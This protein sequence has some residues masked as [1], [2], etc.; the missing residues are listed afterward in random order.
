VR[1][2][3]LRRDPRAIYRRHVVRSRRT[4]LGAVATA[5]SVLAG[6]LAAVP[7]DAQQAQTGTAQTP[8][9]A[10]LSSDP[11]QPVVAT[12]VIV[13]R[14]PVRLSPGTRLSRVR[15]SILDVTGPN[16]AGSVPD[17]AFSVA[18]APPRG[19]G[20]A[21]NLTI[22]TDLARTPGNYTVLL[23]SRSVGR[24]RQT[25]ELSVTVQLA[26]AQVSVPTRL[27]IDQTRG[28]VG[29]RSETRNDSTR[30]VVEETS[31]RRAIPALRVV[32]VERPN[33]TTGENTGV[34]DFPREVPILPGQLR[35]LRY[36]VRGR[37]PLG[38]TTGTLALSAPQLGD[39]ITVPYEVTVKR[40][41]WTLLA[42]LVAGIVVGYAVR[43]LLA[44]HIEIGLARV[45]VQ[46]VRAR[47]DREMRPGHG[48]AE[49]RSA[50]Q[51]IRSTLDE[52][53]GAGHSAQQIADA[54]LKASAALDEALT[55]LKARATAVETS[56]TRF[57]GVLFKQWALPAP[58]TVALAHGRATY[59]AAATALARGDVGSAAAL[60]DAIPD[61]G[62][63]LAEFGRSWQSQAALLADAMHEAGDV[64]AL[65][66]QAA[67]TP[68]RE[69]IGTEVPAD[70]DAALASLTALSNTLRTALVAVS[71]QI[72]PAA[73]H[74]QQALAPEDGASDVGIARADLATVLQ[75]EPVSRPD[76]VAQ[77]LDRLSSRIRDAKLASER[78]T[79]E[80]ASALLAVARA[81]ARATAAEND[82]PGLD[83]RTAAHLLAAFA[84]EL[85]DAAAAAPPDNGDASPPPAPQPSAPTLPTQ[86]VEGVEPAPAVT[87]PTILSG[88][89]LSPAATRRQLAL[90]RLLQTVL[91]GA[92]LVWIGYVFFEDRYVGTDTDMLG[93]FLWA[94]GLDIGL[95]AISRLR[96]QQEAGLGGTGT[97]TAQ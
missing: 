93:V 25:G 71:T 52:E 53:A 3:T 41:P 60:A 18:V 67:E 26:A 51:D 75:S 39:D 89:E 2:L 58:V 38:T 42:L 63:T 31:A 19:R 12:R 62:T 66:L 74:V 28:L 10:L 78:R 61:L 76:A 29:T 92:I 55:A 72:V 46:Q 94:F 86:T 21:I 97:A 40:A 27:H 73:D 65:D 57:Q 43:V 50:V 20:P 87:A 6:I 48:D 1:L 96:P 54:A 24:R 9:I 14:A 44:G 69:K 68:L 81:E 79:A 32:Q 83:P 77:A 90:D 91:V 59:K 85:Q 8:P 17:A 49:F 82:E 95:A 84:G 23:A 13:V 80:R 11:L 4:L 7:A 47:I 70:L 36:D 33:T 56:L 15:V 88:P 37:F 5:G 35:R 45:K 16:G 30:F 64:L 34:I 22:R